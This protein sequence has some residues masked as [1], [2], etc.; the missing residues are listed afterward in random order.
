MRKSRREVIRQRLDYL[1]VLSE[2]YKKM[3]Y[4][5]L[6]R[7]PKKTTLPSS[8]DFPNLKFDVTVQHLPLGELEVEVGYW[9]RHFLFFTTGHGVVFWIKPNGIIET[10]EDSPDRH[11]G[12]DSK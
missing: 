2:G 3:P 1:D 7:M 8:P 6:A 11:Q 4:G 9:K 5:E 10:T 12:C